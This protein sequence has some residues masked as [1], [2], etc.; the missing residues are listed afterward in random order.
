M[1]MRAE[2]TKEFVGQPDNHDLP[3][4]IAVGEILYGRI[5]EEA[6]RLGRAVPAELAAE[7][8]FAPAPET[9]PQPKPAKRARKASGGRD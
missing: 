9:P 6:V 2:V 3:R 1:S 7:A 8:E 4:G 5:A